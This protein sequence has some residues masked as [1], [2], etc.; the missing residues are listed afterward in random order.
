MKD[1]IYF[2]R[3]VVLA[4][5]LVF[6]ACSDDDDKKQGDP[7]FPEVQK[8]SCAVGETVE[9]TFNANMN[10][11][12]SSSALWCKFVVGGELMNSCSGE[13]GEQIG[14]AHV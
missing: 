11:K 2:L 3:F 1:K 9:L 5:C 13:T 7:I 4:F 8:I 10:W 6:V 14:R 12:L